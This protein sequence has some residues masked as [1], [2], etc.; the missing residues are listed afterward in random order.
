MAQEETITILKVGT[1]E[2]VASVNDLKENVKALKSSLGDL[3]IGTEQY[4]KTLDELKVNQN[5]LKDAMY[6][7]TGTMDDISKSAT[8]ASKSYNS[9][10][11]Q[12][13]ALKE[14]F[15]AT[16]SE[17][18]R[19][20]LAPQIKAINDELKRID[21]STG[22]FQ[23]H[24]GDYRNAIKDAFKDIKDKAD[25]L[26]KSMTAVGKGV[27]GV[28]DGADA[29]AKS[30]AFA[31]F[32]LLVS[33][34]IKLADSLKDNE[35]AMAALKKASDALKPVM[36][37]L[38]G[39]MEKVAEHLADII[40]RVV[41]FVTSNGLFTQVINGVVGV[42]NAILK[43]VI[44]PFKGIVKA[45]DVLKD[46][47]VKGLK[48]AAKA[49]G[50]EMK[51]G[52]AFKQNFESGRTI[53]DTIIA[54]AKSKSKDVKDAGTDLG[55]EMGKG[56]ADGLKLSDWKK[57]LAEGDRKLEEERKRILAD[58]AE[59]DKMTEDE[60]ARTTAEIEKYFAEQARIREQDLKDAEE[61]AKAKIATMQG[62]ADATGGILAS[63]ADL[64]ET[65]EKNSEKNA[66]KIKALR[67]ASATI[68]TISGAIGAFMQ[69][70]KTYAP[71]Y[72][73][74]LGAAQ[75]SAIT[76]SGMA[77]IAQIKKV[78]VSGS[79]ASAPSAIPAIVSAPTLNPGMTSV[80]TITSAS[81]EQR[82]NQ[83]AR[84]QRVYIL[85]SDLQADR[86]SVRTRVEETSF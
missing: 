5:A 49:F 82:L 79:S 17:A 55:K 13:A 8:G 25:A 50:D 80:R 71:P 66:L 28:K 83:M 81:E 48:N 64:Y 58:Q 34:A 19:N 44:S 37:F 22:N 70:T 75:A 84:D 23:R 2:A 78:N 1:Q 42:G 21:E 54:G 68:D 7:T 38:S 51:N 77:Q 62:V 31:T 6:A 43:F 32:G 69:A 57:A 60:L 73:A 33:V 53:A 65:D 39:I 86:E 85:S 67:I 27:N 56:I 63:I 9:L 41:T 35:T 14:E 24:V 72:G 59:I 74:I 20:E 40:D 15:R 45:I 76:A 18:R 12:M 11:H 47:G 46:E 61:K 29:L 52:V 10:V 36:D 30:P 26:G 16:N 4:Q 3:E